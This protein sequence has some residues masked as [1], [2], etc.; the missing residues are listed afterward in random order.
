MPT[1]LS[2]PPFALYAVLAV[3]VAVCGA[4]WINRR[5]RRTL[6]VFLGATGVLIALFAIDRLCES[7]REEAV[8]RV[9]AMAQAVDA[10]NP[11]AFLTHVADA[12]EYQGE[13]GVSRL[14]RDDLRRA[15]M[16]SLLQQYSVHVAAWDFDPADVLEL[17][18]NTIEIG[19]LAKAESGDKQIPIYLR[20]KFARQ[21]DGEWK[22]SGLASYDAMKRINERKSI[23]G[24]P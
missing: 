5:D 23:P 3:A 16:W 4:V 12:V 14:T 20:A 18:A 9:L 17:D 15:G 19:F 11:D 8:R 21:G 1:F 6:M 7:P 10:R 24:F 13:G 22:L 2:D